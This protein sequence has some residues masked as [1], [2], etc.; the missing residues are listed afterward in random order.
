M[1][2]SCSRLTAVNVEQAQ[3][4]RA[5]AA[6]RSRLAG[7]EAGRQAWAHQAA[8][9]PHRPHS[10]SVSSTS[11]PRPASTRGAWGERGQEAGEWGC[12][13]LG[14]LSRAAGNR[15]AQ[16]ASPGAAIVADGTAAWP[17]S[18]CRQLADASAARG[19]DRVAAGAGG[20]PGT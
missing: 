16:P 7:A 1:L 2:S 19:L 10:W 4:V 14:M 17:V 9:P 13:Q 3:G 11:T 8:V 18:A 12:P 5:K 6:W 20:S 15:H